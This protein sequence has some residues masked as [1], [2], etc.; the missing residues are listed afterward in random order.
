[1]PWTKRDYI[2]SALD[3]I[4]IANYVFDVQPEQMQFALRKLDAMMAEWNGRGV[5]VGYPL[6]ASPGE[7]EL[8]EQCVVPDW[9]TQAI[10]TGLAIRL[11]PSYGRPVSGELKVA[12]RIAL[13]TVQAR[14]TQLLEMQ[15]P[16]KTPAG[17]GRK[18]WRTYNNPFLRP[19]QEAG[20]ILAG[21]DGI[22]EYD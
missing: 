22:L 3:E 18:F 1:M 2:T 13:N 7:S 16:N 5:R 12:Y 10:V 8:D 20:V 19:P 9:A 21:E 4:G 17:A 6:P 11:A 14:T 15:F